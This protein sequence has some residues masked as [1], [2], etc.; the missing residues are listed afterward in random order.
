MAMLVARM[1]FMLGGLLLLATFAVVPPASAQQRNP[2][3][4][5]GRAA[6]AGNDKSPRRN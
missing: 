6:M 4:G 5:R 1:R 2:D 3:N